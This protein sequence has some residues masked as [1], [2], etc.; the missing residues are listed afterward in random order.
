MN[1]H[2]EWLNI[3][4]VNQ[5][6]TDTGEWVWVS[7]SGKGLSQA[8]RLTS[9]PRSIISFMADFNLLETLSTYIVQDTQFLEQ[10]E[11]HSAAALPLFFSITSIAFASATFLE[12]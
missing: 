3:L 8:Q 10:T 2:R 5:L 7:I 11:I 4:S 12:L 1:T 6:L 9:L